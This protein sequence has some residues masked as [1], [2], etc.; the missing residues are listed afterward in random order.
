MIDLTSLELPVNFH[1]KIQK[2][3]KVISFLSLQ[4]K[5]AAL[6]RGLTL[7]TSA[8]QTPQRTSAVS[9]NLPGEYRRRRPAP[10]HCPLAPPL[11]CP[12]IPRPRCAVCAH[13]AHQ[14]YTPLHRRVPVQLQ[15]ASARR[16]PPRRPAATRLSTLLHPLTCPLPFAG[17][18]GEDGGERGEAAAAGREAWEG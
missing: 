5:S 10:L 3:S 15:A 14:R 2:H 6:F 9:R 12:H 13:P 1:V 16:F 11:H 18:A 8:P 17:V 7:R 4:H